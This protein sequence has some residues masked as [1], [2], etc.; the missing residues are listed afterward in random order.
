MEAAEVVSKQTRHRLVRIQ[1]QTVNIASAQYLVDAGA[2][3]RHGQA[4]A[5]IHLAL[6]GAGQINEADSPSPRHD[7]TLV[8][9]PMYG[10]RDH[11][12]DQ[13][14]IQPAASNGGG[15]A[16][17]LLRIEGRCAQR[18]SA[19]MADPHGAL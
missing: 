11:H 12:M 4:F 17:V 19:Q 7:V 8:K 10:T 3:N 16:P 2:R 18:Q 6:V 1:D 5:G 15:V 14:M 13:I 9:I